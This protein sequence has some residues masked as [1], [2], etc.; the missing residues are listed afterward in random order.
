MTYS[1]NKSKSNSTNKS[2]NKS[3]NK[4][5]K[6]KS[7]STNKSNNKSK[8]KSN[9]SKSNSDK[10]KSK[11]NIKSTNNSKTNTSK[12]KVNNNRVNTT[13]DNINYEGGGIFDFISDFFGYKEEKPL[14]SY[15]EYQKN[16]YEQLKKYDKIIWD[17]KMKIEE[18]GKRN[19]ELI[20]TRNDYDFES[21]EYK[22]LTKN[23]LDNVNTEYELLVKFQNISE[24]LNILR[25]G[26]RDYS[27]S[28]PSNIGQISLNGYINDAKSPRDFSYKSRSLRRYLRN[29]TPMNQ[30][31][32]PSNGPKNKALTNKRY[33]NNNT[34]N[35]NSRYR[36]KQ[37]K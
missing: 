26:G 28:L 15:D 3:K 11:S 5:N 35:N 4:S 33:R 9:K 23:I 30:I 32:T 17:I 10:S 1:T 13:D 19:K 34:R 16:K 29:D 21:N 27:P 18:N 20:N 36:P 12:S 25:E 2:N 37:K 22:E 8:N 31:E 14:S 7:N 6:S 24:E